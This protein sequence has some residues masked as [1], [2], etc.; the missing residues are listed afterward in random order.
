M[1]D[2]NI[3]DVA[4]TLDAAAAKLNPK[5]TAARPADA[6]APLEPALEADRFD[7]DLDDLL[8]DVR[9]LARESGAFARSEDEPRIRSLYARDAANL[10]NQFGKL[11][12]LRGK[13]RKAV[14]EER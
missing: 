10:A 2:T 11:L 13:H 7:G 5:R 4:A 3:A 8:G 6:C 14:R 1:T 9:D 12:L